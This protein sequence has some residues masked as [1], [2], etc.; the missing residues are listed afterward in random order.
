M[1]EPQVEQ[2]AEQPYVAIR[3]RITMDGFADAIDSAFPALFG[4]LSERDVQPAGPPFIRYLKVDVERELEIDLGVPVAQ[5]VPGDDRIQ[6]GA[7]PAG[8]YATLMHVGPYGGL[9]DAHAALQEWG[10]RK[11]LVLRGRV[12]TY[13]TDPSREPDSSRWQTEL[14]YLVV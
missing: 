6:A 3:R 4:W 13:V 11:G 7:L 10:A 9:R 14:A 2:G 12:E 5:S 8:R 1:A